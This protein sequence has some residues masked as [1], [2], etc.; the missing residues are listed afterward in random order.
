ML[1]ERWTTES[2]LGL[3]PAPISALF[4]YFGCDLTLYFAFLRTFSLWL[5][6]PAVLGL[7][8]FVFQVAGPRPLCPCPQCALA[9]CAHRPL[10][11]SPSEPLCSS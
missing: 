8:L 1:E 7:V 4:N 9:P 10:R 11:A 6:L 3:A 5:W 2:S